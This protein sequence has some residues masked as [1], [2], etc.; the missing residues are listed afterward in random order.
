MKRVGL[1]LL[2]FTLF[3]GANAANQPITI[4]KDSVKEVR[5]LKTEK[6]DNTAKD[7]MLM[8]KLSAEQLMQLEQE[9]LSVERD[10]IEAA[11][12]EDM[13]LNG[14]G[15]VI[16]SLLPFL[17]VAVI[18]YITSKAKNRES[19]RRYDLYMK[20][21]EMG[22][23]IPEHFFDVAKNPDT[24]SNLKRGILWLVVGL[25]LVIS[26]LIMDKQNSLIAGIIPT[27]VGIGYLLV[28]VLEKPKTNSTEK[29]DE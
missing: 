22:Q 14:F 26:F 17:L 23:T 11:S 8:E 9:K 2:A 4:H 28:H 5:V 3:V 16:I 10:R 6:I 18:I 29:K 7:S 25:A 27:F 12:K 13:P 24:S 15:I 20:S 21:L 19:Q 1:L